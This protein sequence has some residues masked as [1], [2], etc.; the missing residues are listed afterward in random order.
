[1]PSTPKRTS[2]P[3]AHQDRKA[4]R[5]RAILSAAVRA[6]SEL[7]YHGCT[8]SRIAREAGVAD[9]TLYL[10]FRGKEDLLVSS[11]EHVLEEM[12]AEMDRRTGAAP[13]AEQKLR[14]ATECHFEFLENDPHLARFLQFQLR[15][16]DDAIRKAIATPLGRYARRIEAI[17]DQG[18]GAGT[19]RDGIATSVLRRVYFGAVDETISAWL[20]RS[21]GT[22]LKARAEPVLDVLLNGMRT[23]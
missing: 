23:R 9:G 14:A 4:G 3:T 18:K 6:F 19:F 15:Q 13:D 7:G 12:L 10:Y 16:P 5:Q 17:I 1:M 20:L 21:D 22:S 2:R 8:V 11:F